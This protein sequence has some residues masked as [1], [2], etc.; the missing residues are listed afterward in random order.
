MDQ[1]WGVAAVDLLDSAVLRTPC[2]TW[3]GALRRGEGELGIQEP[4]TFKDVA[5]DVSQEE[6]RQ[7][8]LTERTLYHSMML[9][10]YGHLLPGTRSPSLRSFPCWSKESSHGWGSLHILGALIQ[11]G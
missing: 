8:A 9:E 11:S 1:S 10:T 6:E 3:I 4:A 5:V 2:S 7:L